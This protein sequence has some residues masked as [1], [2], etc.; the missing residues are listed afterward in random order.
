MVFPV[1][2]GRNRSDFLQVKLGRADG[3]NPLK[4]TIIDRSQL[5]LVEVLI[6]LTIENGIGTGN[7]SPRRHNRH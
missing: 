5:L 7:S 6:S 2:W 3:G 1:G 4:V